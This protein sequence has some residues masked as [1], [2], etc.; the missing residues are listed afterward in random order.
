[1]ATDRLIIQTV[2]VHGK[3]RIQIPKEVRQILGISDGDLLYFVQDISGK[4]FLEK[5]PTLK[6]GPGK[7]LVTK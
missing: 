2:K 6:K 5:A 4:I 1:M 3:G 7:Y